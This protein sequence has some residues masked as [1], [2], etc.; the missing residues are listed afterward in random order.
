MYIHF[1]LENQILN[2]LKKEENC[3]IIEKKFLKLDTIK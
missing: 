3:K 1:F 2:P